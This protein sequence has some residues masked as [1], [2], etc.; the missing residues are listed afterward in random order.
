M[1]TN[2]NHALLI[3]VPEAAKTLGIS[4]RTLF[5]LT[6]RGEVPCVRIGRRVLYLPMAL[7]VWVK[8]G[9]TR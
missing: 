6:K 8:N 2:R 5:D 3:S 7:D 1:E 4:T 9:G